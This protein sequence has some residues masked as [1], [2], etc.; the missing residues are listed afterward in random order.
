MHPAHPVGVATGQVVVDGD[1]VD[2]VAGQRVQVDRQGGDERLALT[3]LHLGDVAQVQRR[4]AHQLHLVVE[5]TEGAAGGLAHDRE[6]LGQQVV[7]RLAVAVALLERVGERA[8]FGVGQ[9]DVVVLERLDVIGN[10]RK[11]ADLSCLHR[12]AEAWLEP[13]RPWYGASRARPELVGRPVCQADPHGAVPR[14]RARRPGA[15]RS[16]R[17]LLRRWRPATPTGCTRSCRTRTMDEFLAL[18][19]PYTRE[20]ARRWAGQLG[21]EGRREGTGLGCAV[22]EGRRAGWSVRPRSGSPATRRSGTGWPRT[23]AAPGYAA[24]ATRVLS[25]WG[26][27]LGS[28]PDPVAVRRAK[29]GLGPHRAVGGLPLRGCRAQR[30]G[31]RRHRDGAGAPRRPGPVRPPRRRPARADRV[32]LRPAARARVDRRGAPAADD[33][34]TPTRPR[35]PR[36]TTSSRCGGASP[37][38]PTRPRRAGTWPP[39]PAWTG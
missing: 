11:S 12:R 1:D 21:D 20:E 37:A 16:E 31:R 9:I 19:T 2:A 33:A 8:Q 30:V 24:E 3:G 29:P 14:G 27:G 17:L 34:R 5:L 7:E 26:F 22:V 15:R 13:R 36:P 28:A 6:R 35:W 10:G 23:P 32:R 38:P 25:G 4:T 18:P 39:G